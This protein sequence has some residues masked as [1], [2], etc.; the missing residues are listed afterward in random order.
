M[1]LI[2][3]LLPF[4]AT[5]V[6]ANPYGRRGYPGGGDGGGGG[7]GGD[8]SG[9]DGGGGDGG[10]G[11]SYSACTGL[12]YNTAQCCATDVGGVADLDCENRKITHSHPRH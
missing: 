9:G 5:A 11:G 3:L 12:L 7:G 2:T 8:G 6:L 10:G 1:Q 4:L